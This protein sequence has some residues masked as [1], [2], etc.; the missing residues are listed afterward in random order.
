MDS[1]SPSNDPGD[2][3]G[4]GNDSG[5]LNNAKMRKRTKTGCLTCR[6]RRIKCGEERPTC[7]N[8]IKSKR[9][10]EGYNQRVIFK[11]PIGDWPNHPGVVSTLPYHS[12]M[13]PGTRAGYRSNQSTTL[14]Q[15]APRTLAQYE[16]SNISTGPMPGQD[17]VNQS[18]LVGGSHNYSQDANYQQP[19]HSPHHQQSLHSPHHQLPTPTSATSYFAT[20][21][22]PIHPSIS[23]PFAHDSNVAY[24][25][26]QRYPHGSHYPQASVP[27][28]QP[29][30]EQGVYQHMQRTSAEQNSYPLP[31]YPPL[32]A[33]GY[34][35]HSDATHRFN[36]H[37]QIE[38]Q[39]LPSPRGDFSHAG[40]Y[41]HLHS[42]ADADSTHSTFHP[43]QIPSHSFVSDVK[44]VPQHAHVLGMSRV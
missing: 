11:P 6:K 1:G 38:V 20:Q 8:C 40:S 12:S 19:L 26:Q 4:P 27:Y 2:T 28:S 30:H 41:S 35:P 16:F 31:S 29:A 14:P 18:V 13:L 43:V 33:G 39:A 10:C 34:P 23:G 21:P 37:S 22:S 5:S 32:Q 15:D 42:T 17:I 3:S 44:Y 24:D 25:A 36:S 9:Q 7:G